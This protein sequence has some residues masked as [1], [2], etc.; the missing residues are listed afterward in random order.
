MVLPAIRMRS[1]QLEH[2]SPGWEVIPSSLGFPITGI[3]LGIA[4][5]P[6][7][8]FCLRFQIDF[9]RNVRSAIASL[10][11]RKDERLLFDQKAQTSFTIDDAMTSQEKRLEEGIDKD[12]GSRDQCPAHFDVGQARP[13]RLQKAS[14]SCADFFERAFRRQ[15]YRCRRLGR[16]DGTTIFAVA[17]DS[18][19][20]TSSAALHDRRRNFDLRTGEK[21]DVGRG[22][23]ASAPARRA[24]APAS[25]EPALPSSPAVESEH[26]GA[27]RSF[28]ARRLRCRSA[29]P[30]GSSASTRRDRKVRSCPSMPLALCRRSLPQ[31]SG[32]STW[33][34]VCPAA[35]E[36]CAM[37]AK[38]FKHGVA[39]TTRL[40]RRN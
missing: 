7:L 10:R 38:T 24:A 29:S 9:V 26:R 35:P 34:P 33:H 21:V 23:L 18:R 13:R 6:I 25:R 39:E 12:L 5:L 37:Q 40:L 8:E 31:T 27:R 20:C 2:Q 16:S 28:A 36:R 14:L 17:A 11:N 3:Q 19:A 32:R 22:H 1:L 4:A 30:H 15:R